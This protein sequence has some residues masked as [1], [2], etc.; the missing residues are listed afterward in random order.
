MI[1]IAGWKAYVDCGMMFK[2]VI[3]FWRNLNL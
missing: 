2:L 3:A 1:Y